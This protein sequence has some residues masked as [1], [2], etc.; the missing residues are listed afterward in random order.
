MAITMVVRFKWLELIVNYGI[1]SNSTNYVTKTYRI[2]KTTIYNQGSTNFQIPIHVF[3]FIRE[4]HSDKI[5][6][7]LC[8]R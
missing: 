5:L 1:T 6:A 7:Y 3:N 4:I 2:V 8:I